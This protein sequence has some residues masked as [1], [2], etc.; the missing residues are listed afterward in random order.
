MLDELH[1]SVNN[2]MNTVDQT[3][4]IL[5]KIKKETLN[6]LKMF[7]KRKEALNVYARSN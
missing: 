3:W 5:Q 7:G 2:T 6:E 1:E 4:K